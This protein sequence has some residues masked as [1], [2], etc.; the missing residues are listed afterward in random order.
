MEYFI[1]ILSEMKS[2]KRF[3]WP[4]IFYIV[5]LICCSYQIMLISIHYFNY[6]ITVNIE[7][8]FDLMYFPLPAISFCYKHSNK[9]EIIDKPIEKMKSDY[10]ISHILQY[11]CITSMYSDYND[12]DINC[13]SKATVEMINNVYY[14]LSI[15]FENYGKKTYFISTSSY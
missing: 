9:S 10:E 6:P 5:L 3:I 7:S 13:T 8:Q 14:C 2:P 12:C 15:N 1:K 11:C 4:A